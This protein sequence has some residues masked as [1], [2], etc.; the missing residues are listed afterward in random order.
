MKRFAIILILVGLLFGLA[1]AF[2]ATPT[3]CPGCRNTPTATVCEACRH[4]PTPT[5]CA[6][7]RNTPTPIPGMQ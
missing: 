7:C 6:A 3:I 4:T 1:F 5:P 2:Q